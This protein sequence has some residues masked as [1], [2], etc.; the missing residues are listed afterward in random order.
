MMLVLL[1]LLHLEQ[2]LC[3]LIA[4]LN[5]PPFTDPTDYQTGAPHYAGSLPYSSNTDAHPLM[6]RCTCRCL[7]SWLELVL[8]LGPALAGC[9]LPGALQAAPP[10]LLQPLLALPPPRQLQHSWPHRRSLALDCRLFA[11][12]A[13]PLQRQRRWAWPPPAPQTPVRRPRSCA[14][15]SRTRPCFRPWR[16]LAPA[17]GARSHPPAPHCHR[18]RA[19]AMA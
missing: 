12:A 3:N 15:C 1:A 5:A 16:W 17:A 10:A 19:I 14:D 18:L 4:T 2:D 8:V 9:Q 6:R 13:R 7:L 11:Q